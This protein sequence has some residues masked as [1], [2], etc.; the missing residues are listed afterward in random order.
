VLLEQQTLVVVVVAVEAA[1]IWSV[2][3]V[4]KM[5]VLAVRVL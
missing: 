3:C 4:A 1:P 5:V 2:D